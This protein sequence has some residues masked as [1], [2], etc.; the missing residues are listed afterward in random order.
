MM[1]ARLA[2]GL[3]LLTGCAQ[4]WHH[5]GEPVTFAT[6]SRDWHACVAYAQQGRGQDVLIVLP[7]TSIYVPGDFDARQTA[8]MK[9]RGYRRDGFVF[10]W[11][12]MGWKDEGAPSSPADIERV[13]NDLDV[14]NWR[15]SR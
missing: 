11:K 13:I 5:T 6:Y 7:T 12:E 10:G 15:R 3:L 14:S 1:Y 9:D 4:H 2:L 8:C